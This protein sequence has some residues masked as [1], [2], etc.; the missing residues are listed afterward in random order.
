ML[1]GLPSRR[2]L[3]TSAAGMTGEVGVRGPADDGSWGRDGEPGR[4]P[5]PA[6]KRKKPRLGLLAGGDGA[7]GSTGEEAV[8]SLSLLPAFF[9]VETIAGGLRGAGDGLPADT[10]GGAALVLDGD[11]DSGAVGL[12]AGSAVE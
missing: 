6:P 12:C 8:L 10:W 9:P 4:N 1:S 7:L 11:V 5:L 2:G 3:A